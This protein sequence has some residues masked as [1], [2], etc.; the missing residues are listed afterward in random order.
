MLYIDKSISTPVCT[1]WTVDMTRIF[2]RLGLS[3][4][5]VSIYK[6]CS[7]I[8]VQAHCVHTKDVHLIIGGF[9]SSVIIQIVT[10]GE[11]VQYFD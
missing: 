3:S 5:W 8:S 7:Y 1:E 10:G 11:D 4:A 9:G 6:R 2:N